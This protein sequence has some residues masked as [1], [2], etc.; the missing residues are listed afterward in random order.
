MEPLLAGLLVGFGVPRE[1]LVGTA[2]AIKKK[3]SGDR[4][5]TLKL[6]NQGVKVA[7]IVFSDIEL[8][9]NAVF[10]GPLE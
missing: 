7:Y 1:S 4:S 10:H 9:R 3:H 5:P 8:N 6:T 2:E